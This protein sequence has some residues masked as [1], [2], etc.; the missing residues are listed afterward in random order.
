MTRIF[1]VQRVLAVVRLVSFSSS[2]SKKLC[3]TCNPSITFARSPDEAKYYPVSFEQRDKP[4]SRSPL[5]SGLIT[6]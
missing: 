6:G 5:P 2:L 4:E 1:L 3:P